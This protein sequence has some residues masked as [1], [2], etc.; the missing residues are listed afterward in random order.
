VRVVTLTVQNTE[1]P[2]ERQA[3]LNRAAACTLDRPEDGLWASDHHG[4][5][6]D[7]DLSVD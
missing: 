7:L 5:V 3:L 1:G 6:A 4:V 2:P